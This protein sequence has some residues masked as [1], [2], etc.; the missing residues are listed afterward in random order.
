MPAHRDGAV[1]ARNITMPRVFG[2]VAGISLTEDA[3]YVVAARPTP[4][5]AQVIQVGAAPLPEGALDNGRVHQSE[6][7][8][9]AIRALLKT[10]AVSARAAVIG[11]P[12]RAVFTRT[13]TIP[14]VPARERRALVR[15]E[16]EH[17]NVLPPG[18]GAFDFVSL[19]RVENAA[20]RGESVLFFAAEHSVVEG[21]RSAV[22]KAGLRLVGMEPS[23]FAAIRAVYPSLADKPLALAISLGAYHTNLMFLK[24]GQAVYSR[25]LDVGIRQ[26]TVPELTMSPTGRIGGWRMVDYWGERPS[27]RLDSKAEQIA[28]DIFGE[29]ADSGRPAREMLAL[30]IA[31]SLE[32]YRR[33]YA[34]E[35]DDIHVV[36]LPNHGELAKLPVYVGAALGQEV[37]S[38][39]PFEHAPAPG[40]LLAHLSPEQSVAYAPALGLALGPLGGRFAGA[41]VLD[42]SVEDA[43]VVHARQATRLFAGALAASAALVVLSA[44]GTVFL[45]QRHAPIKQELQG[46][47]QELQFL[48]QQEQALLARRQQQRDL[49]QQ[50]RSRNV[51]WINVLHYLAQAIPP[52]V[53]ITNVAAEGTKLTVTAETKDAGMIPLVWGRMKSSPFFADA[54]VTSITS[55]DATTTFQIS[56][57]LP[58]PA[59]GAAPTA[60]GAAPLPGTPPG[61]NP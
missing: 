20:T 56:V 28:G 15:G 57:T 48:T 39:N 12:S 54:D 26:I 35:I 29:T 11:L 60:P 41:P 53:G 31:R 58:A 19:A 36:L 24:N 9:A 33:E 6:L 45:A 14:P 44:A 23:E 32:Y 10:H 25:R 38:A 51:P 27:E 55:G 4:S 5:G 2:P 37:A 16:I 8:A 47:R 46:A 52:S 21:Y 43:A 13:V 17:L 49:V 42:L 34:A 3:I 61:R 59:A 50:I 7:L 30:E 40:G 22:R 18:K 1:V